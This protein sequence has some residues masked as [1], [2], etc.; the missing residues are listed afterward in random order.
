MA[1]KLYTLTS[2]GA[3]VVTALGALLA[4][5]GRHQTAPP[6]TPEAVDRSGAA[7]DL[8]AQADRLK[9]RLA[10]A[11]AYRQ[12]SRDA[13]RF[14]ASRRPVEAAPPE[15]A[16]SPAAV[17]PPARPPYALAGMAMSMENGVAQRTAILSS[18]QGVSLVKEGEVLTTGYRVLSIA[19]DAV[20]LESTND[21]TQTTLRLPSA[22]LR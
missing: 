21:G 7:I 5:T 12:P 1:S 15:A 6:A 3:I 13:F 11:T 8:G 22:G 19:D 10:E 20:T 4:P 18:L 17:I 14:G 9:A 16:G 2:G